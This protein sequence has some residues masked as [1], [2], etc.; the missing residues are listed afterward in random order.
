MLTI[1]IPSFDEGPTIGIV[2]WRL[3]KVFEAE[4]REYEVIVLDDGSTDATAE[5]LKQYARVMPLTVI[6]HAE[7]RGAGRAR[8]RRRRAHALPA[9][10]CARVH[11]G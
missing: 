6:R 3:R 7:P 8:A 5:T 9:S 1:C 10:R 2:L 11:A 4:P